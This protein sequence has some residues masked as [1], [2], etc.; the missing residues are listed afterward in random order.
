MYIGSQ[1]ANEIARFS[2]E[3]LDAGVGMI[4][5]RKTTTYGT[6]GGVQVR[7]WGSRSTIFKPSPPG[8]HLWSQVTLLVCRLSRL[9]LPLKQTKPQRAIKQAAWVPSNT[10]LSSML[11]LAKAMET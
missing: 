5:A 1:E 6:D 7:R 2:K 10:K 9:P 4:R 3:I 8:S 11:I